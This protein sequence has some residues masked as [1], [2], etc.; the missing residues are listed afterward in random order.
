[1][2]KAIEQLWKVSVD[3][4]EQGDKKLEENFSLI[5]D[6]VKSR[7]E[8]LIS[9]DVFTQFLDSKLALVSDDTYKGEVRKVLGGRFRKNKLVDFTGEDHGAIHALSQLHKIPATAAKLTSRRLQTNLRNMGERLIS[10]NVDVLSPHLQQSSD[11]DYNSEKRAQYEVCMDHHYRLEGIIKKY[12]NGEITKAQA[13]HDVQAIMVEESEVDTEKGFTTSLQE[14]APTSFANVLEHYALLATEPALPYG[15][16]PEPEPALEPEPESRPATDFTTVSELTPRGEEAPEVVSAPVSTGAP[17]PPPLPPPLP[18]GS[19]FDSSIDALA[20]ARERQQAS[21]DKPKE[22]A[23]PKS[24]S[25]EEALAAELQERFGISQEPKKA[26]AEE[27]VTD[28]EWEVEDVEAETTA[29]PK[30]APP[31]SSTTS[32]RLE[33]RGAK[34]S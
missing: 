22:A 13:C 8:G 31:P 27:L 5:L 10:Y 28:E 14:F 32:K 24:R 12:I 33:G 7:S 11:E 26:A 30:A 18:K 34:G 16:P 4:M 23:P 3:I 20:L 2:H 21:K 6:G 15:A 29:P 17:P 25:L 9:R 1:M 19:L